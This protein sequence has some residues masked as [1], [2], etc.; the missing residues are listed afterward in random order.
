MLLTGFCCASSV[1]LL[2]LLLW[3]LP[4]AQQ[5]LSR[6]TAEAQQKHSRSSEAHFSGANVDS[7]G[8]TMR[9]WV[10]WCLKHPTKT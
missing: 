3:L 8:S 6:N 7:F 9:A 4:E 1:L 2:W 5:K 10:G